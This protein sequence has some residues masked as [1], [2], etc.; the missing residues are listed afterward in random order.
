ML[1]VQMR[2]GEDV[3]LREIINDELREEFVDGRSEMRQIAKE[4]IA[5][6][7]EENR[8]QFDKKR[9]IAHIYRVGDLCAIARTQFGTG[10]KLQDKYFGP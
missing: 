8:K 6:V 9:S 2:T 4:Q 3:S 1:G 7:Q 5:R 10:L